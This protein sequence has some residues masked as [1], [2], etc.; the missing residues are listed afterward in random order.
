MTLSLARFFLMLTLAAI[1]ATV[2]ADPLREADE[3]LG[4]R[5]AAGAIRILEQASNA[6]NTAAKGRLASY[7]RTFP[8]P[9]GNVEQ[10]CSLAHEASDAGDAVGSA[11]RADCL[12]AGTEKA[13]QPFKLAR[14]LARKALDSGFAPAG[15]S[16]YQA[17]VLDP[18]YRLQSGNFGMEKYNAL[19]AMPISA[20]GDQIDAF[21]GLTDAVRSGHINSVIMAM[22]YLMESSAP[23]NID[24]V[25]GLASALQKSGQ[26]IPQRM[27]PTLG[28]AQDIKRLGTTHA[29]VTAFGNAYKPAFLAATLHIR[30][31]GESSCDVKEIKL[32]QVA[33]GPVDNAEYLP[34]SKAPLASTYLVRG[35]WN[36]TWTFAGC[37]KSAPIDMAFSADGWSGAKFTTTQTPGKPK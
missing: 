19:A 4:K 9:Y 25:L 32:V 2:L 22:A 6:G 13:D 1:A 27:Q 28:L 35:N 14:A 11:T 36:E 18:Q 26:T 24:R 23:G 3:A 16:L 34:I 15:L 29:S 12:V 31:L 5:D 8:P 10:G 21:E 17:F 7:L 37:Q 30:G 33:A 20:R